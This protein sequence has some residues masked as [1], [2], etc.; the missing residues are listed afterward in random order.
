MKIK[1]ER[2]P[3]VC[4]VMLSPKFEIWSIHVVVL[5]S[6][7]KKCTEMRAACARV[8]DVKTSNLVI[9]RRRYAENRTNIC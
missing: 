8:V 4:A 2:F 7:A 9:S 1:S 6:T 5:R 3:V